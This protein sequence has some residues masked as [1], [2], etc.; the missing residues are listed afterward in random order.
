MTNTTDT[1]PLKEDSCKR[2][3]IWHKNLYCRLILLLGAFIVVAYYGDIVR[4]IGACNKIPGR[5]TPKEQALQLV[6]KKKA[7]NAIGAYI[8]SM[9][10]ASNSCKSQFLDSKLFDEYPAPAP[11]TI[12]HNKAK[13][14]GVKGKMILPNRPESTIAYALTITCCPDFVDS[15]DH[16]TF[17]PGNIILEATTIIKDEICDTNDALE[18]MRKR[19]DSL[20]GHTL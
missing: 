4:S 7:T 13:I 10:K 6:E 9:L 12:T 14:N 17:D 2:S 16:E 20:S 3:S 18:L 19:N 8:D 5:G 15:A 1:G 11:S